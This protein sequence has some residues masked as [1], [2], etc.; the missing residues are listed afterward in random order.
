MSNTISLPQQAVFDVPRSIAGHTLLLTNINGQLHLSTEQAM[1]L[2]GLTDGKTF[3]HHLEAALVDV[4]SRGGMPSPPLDSVRNPSDIRQYLRHWT[5]CRYT[6]CTVLSS[7]VS[8]RDR[9]AHA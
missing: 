8:V 9:D 1:Q 5:R 2:V 4:T 3:R 7:T 6:N